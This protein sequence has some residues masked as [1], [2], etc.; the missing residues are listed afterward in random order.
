MQLPVTGLYA[1]LMA[2]FALFLSFQAGT[3]RSRSGISILFGSPE[4]LELAEH[5]RRH[6]NF[7]EYV[8]MIIIVM[9]VVEL[10]GGS[11]TFLHG[12]GIALIVARIAHA[13]GLKHD[14][15]SHPGRIVGAGGTALITLVVAL[16]AL[17]LQFA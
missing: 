9:A 4:N 2:L 17:W 5:V 1:A 12:A 13:V 6:Q 7:L 3:A 14:R 15:I 16:Y 10:S 11:A 8:P